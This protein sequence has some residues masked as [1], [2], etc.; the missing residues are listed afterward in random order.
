MI[1]YLNKW[2]DAI[3][4]G[5]LSGASMYAYKAVQASNGKRPGGYPPGLWVG[6]IE[7]CRQRNI[8]GLER[9]EEGK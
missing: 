3:C 5:D 8:K 4:I 1:I 2:D 6:F 7:W 9:L